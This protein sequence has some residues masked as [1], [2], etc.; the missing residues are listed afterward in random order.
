MRNISPL[1]QLAG[2][3]AAGQMTRNDYV[4]IRTAMIDQL[5]GVQNAC[6][7]SDGLDETDMTHRQSSSEE[8]SVQSVFSDTIDDDQSV[9]VADPFPQAS[10]SLV[11]SDH[12]VNALASH[13][14]A[15]VLQVNSQSQI[16][17]ID[18]PQVVPPVR[19]FG[20]Q[21]ELIRSKRQHI[22]YA[23]IGALTLA[24]L[25][26]IY[27]LQV[28]ASPAQEKQMASRSA[29]VRQQA[30]VEYQLTQAEDLFVQHADALLRMNN[31]SVTETGTL[32]SDWSGLSVA[33]KENVQR[34]PAFSALQQDAFRRAQ[35]VS[36]L[37]ESQGDSQEEYKALS[38]LSVM[39]LGG[40]NRLLM[41]LKKTPV[42]ALDDGSAASEGVNT[43]NASLS[44]RHLDTE[45]TNP[46]FGT[47][48][49]LAKTD[50]EK[51]DP[52]S[53]KEPLQPVT[54]KQGV[55]QNVSDESIHSDALSPSSAVAVTKAGDSCKV[56]AGKIC[57]DALGGGKFGPDLVVLP[58][59]ATDAGVVSRPFAISRFE[60]MYSEYQLYLVENKLENNSPYKSEHDPIVNVSQVEAVAYAEWLSRKTGHR[61]RLPSER[62]WEYAARG[63]SSDQWISGD[64]FDIG[65]VHAGRISPVKVDDSGFPPNGFGLYHVIGNVAEWISNTTSEGNVENSRMDQG[66]TTSGQIHEVSTCFAKGGSYRKTEANDFS[67]TAKIK[68]KCDKGNAQTG[69]RLI[70][71][72]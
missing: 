5:C 69:F 59:G 30:V 39:P 12:L 2:K 40:V 64:T 8:T 9:N 54:E 65:R 60:I 50:M 66:V 68:Q 20:T 44:S 29:D 24:V 4:T 71:E 3:F 7:T 41:D 45:V 17:S 13:S 23:I 37:W 55:E 31:W 34:L 47:D 49:N 26:L 35:N 48:D 63:G 18:K 43:V 38:S 22:L 46:A 67:Y 72:L 14:A 70:R 56:Q 16:E 6:A 15:A 51:I 19:V 11:S 61:Y 62:E 1:H 33:E 53:G 32:L 28:G 36:A 21:T 57:H 25:T 52:D 27:L 10:V 42:L 58:S